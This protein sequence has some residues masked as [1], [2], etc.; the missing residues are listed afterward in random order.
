MECFCF[1]LS[2]MR[3]E[4]LDKCYRLKLA[5]SRKAYPDV[6]MKH[7]YQVLCVFRSFAVNSVMV[8]LNHS[9]NAS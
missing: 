3:S 7:Y 5:P 8:F 2:H 6:K 1:K 4:N 9:M